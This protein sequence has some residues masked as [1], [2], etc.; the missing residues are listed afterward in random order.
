MLYIKKEVVGP[1]YSSGQSNDLSTLIFSVQ[2][3]IFLCFQKAYDLSTVVV[4][5]EDVSHAPP[6]S[7][8]RLIYHQK[9]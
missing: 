6:H 5:L 4:P 2:N 8:H 9:E 3:Y 1:K 7:Y